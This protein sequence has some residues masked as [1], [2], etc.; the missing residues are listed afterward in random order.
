MKS[1]SPFLTLCI[2]LVFQ[3]SFAQ[4]LKIININVGQGDATLIMGPEQVDGSRIT[5]LFDAGDINNEDGGEIIRKVLHDNQISH[6]DYVIISHYDADHIGGLI[7]GGVH[8]TSFLHG[9]DG[10]PGGGDDI[11]VGTFVDRG[12]ESPHTSQAYRKY[13]DLANAG[14]RI[15]LT[16]QEI[17]NNF[18]IELGN[19]AEAIALAANGFVK[20]ASSPVPNV[21]TENE[22]SLSFLIRFNQFDYLISGD[23]IGRESGSEDAESEKAVGKWIADKAI[24]VDVLHVNH[25]GGN[26]ASESTFLELIK[27]GV[28]IISAG[29]GNSHHH[30]NKYVLKRLE[31]AGVKEI[32]QTEWGSTED[33]IPEAIREIQSIY[34]SHIVIR[35]DGTGFEVSTRKN[36]SCE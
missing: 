11:S 6:L 28:A 12:D 16:N 33:I 31:E 14:Q 23:L 34:Q 7:S 18:K 36:F 22:R 26:N 25:H 27:P 24:V 4:E 1:L 8:G 21:N 17:L 29:N 32:I 10:E 15:S 3:I 13:R 19:G 20:D 35:S 9:M 5:I 30:P 2:L